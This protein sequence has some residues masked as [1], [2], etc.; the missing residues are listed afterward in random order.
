MGTYTTII[1]SKHVR[2]AT[3]VSKECLESMDK[4]PV[5]QMEIVT[6]GTNV[7]S[8]E[9]A[10]FSLKLEKFE[11]KS[12]QKQTNEVENVISDVSLCSNT[13]APSGFS[14]ASALV[15]GKAKPMEPTMEEPKKPYQYRDVTKC[16]VEEETAD[17]NKY[18]PNISED[19]FLEFISKK[20]RR[21]RKTQSQSEHQDIIDLVDEVQ[22]AAQE[23][24][25][26]TVN[27][28]AYLESKGTLQIKEKQGITCNIE[29]EE[30]IEDEQKND[31]IKE[32][33]EYNDYKIDSKPEVSLENLPEKKKRKKKTKVKAEDEIAKALEEISK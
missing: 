7:D 3:Y 13:E 10:P 33:L 29:S 21:R 18:A 23:N 5:E 12:L 9:T 22:G 11:N 14:Y 8:T 24:D 27:Q 25:H 15:I 2:H 26:K 31:Q 17:T 1:K 32:N 20:E 30:E 4:E 28:E 16:P 19:G 6:E